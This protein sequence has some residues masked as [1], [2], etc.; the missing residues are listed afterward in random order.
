MIQQNDFFY[1]ELNF[2]AQQISHAHKG[3]TDNRSALVQLMAWH[4][5]ALPKPMPTK[6]IDVHMYKHHKTSL[7]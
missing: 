2:T 4:R 6:F 3:P 1:F 5:T 7:Y